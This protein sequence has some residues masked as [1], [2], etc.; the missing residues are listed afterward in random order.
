M[1]APTE[2]G[3]GQ[4]RRTRPCLGKWRV[5]IR[6]SRLTS[7]GRWCVKLYAPGETWL[8]HWSDSMVADSFEEAIAFGCRMLR[9]EENNAKAKWWGAVDNWPLAAPRFPAVGP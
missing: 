1:G 2:Q 6:K 8:M 7:T 9:R 5:R 4:N 3:H